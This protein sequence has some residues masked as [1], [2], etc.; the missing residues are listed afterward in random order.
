MSAAYR[1]RF[2]FWLAAVGI[3]ASVLTGYYAYSRSGQMLQHAA[4]D[5][6][7]TAT[8]VLARRTATAFELRAQDVRFIG[9]LPQARQLAESAPP[10]TRAAQLRGL[11]DIFTALLAAHP[12]YYQA[13]IIGLAD[14]GRELVRVD[15]EDA[16]LQPVRGADLQEKGHLPYVFEALR[17]PPGE[18]YFSR[19]GLNHETGAQQGLDKPS[20]RLVSVMRDAHGEPFALAVIGMS[21]DGLFQRLRADLPKDIK[22]LVTNEQGDYLA[23]PDPEKTFGFDRGRRALIQD[24]IA[25]AAAILDRRA[26]NSVLTVSDDDGDHRSVGAFVRVPVGAAREGRFLLVGLVTPMESVLQQTRVLGLNLIEVA[27]VFC[28]AVLAA[29]FLLARLLAQP[30]QAFAHAMRRQDEQADGPSGE[31]SERG[32]LAKAWQT[33]GATLGARS[34]ELRARQLRAEYAG[35]HDPLT[36][37]PTRALMLDRLLQALARVKSGGQSCAVLCIDLDNFTDLNDSLGL[38]VGDEV[39]RAAAQ[40]MRAV[41]RPEDTLARLAGDAFTV[42]IEQAGG[43]GEVRRLAGELV[44]AFDEPFTADGNRFY[45]TCTIGISLCPLHGEQAEEL[46]M[47]ADAAMHAAKADGRNTYRV[48]GEALSSVFDAR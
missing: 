17:Q 31:D 33:V 28:L 5:K 46:L 11:E 43:L 14:H 45:I 42:L 44:A 47:R 38:P 18:V 41:L 34:G 35:L 23:H 22:V 16:G 10:A 19:I 8:Q 15:R 1:S 25:A 7:L 13:R 39:L 48:H 20:I 29:A 3:S 40:R 6:L 24:D 4:E 9:A 12:E 32:F 2:G 27:F 30:L 21:L 36:G 26:N 37:L